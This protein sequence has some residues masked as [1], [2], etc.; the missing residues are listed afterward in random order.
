[1]VS[2]ERGQVFTLEAFIAALLVLSSIV[3]VLSAV[4]ATPLSGSSSNRH[5]ENQQASLANGILDT[6]TAN[7]EL[8]STLLSWDDSNGTFHGAQE[9]GYYLSCSFDTAFGELL[10]RTLYDN[11]IACTV[12][13][14][15]LT[16]GRDIR[17]ERLVYVGEPTDNAV[18]GQ[19]TVVLYDD[20]RLVDASGSPTGTTLAE[21]ATFYAPDA[22]PD[23]RLYNVIEVEVILWRI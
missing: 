15:Y 21:S 11:G 17:S 23:D 1:M 5:V 12:S 6:A 13:L 7:D 16:E 4:T 2:D 20:D 3:F 19:T 14:Q 22:A 8:R 10:A 9:K 18:R